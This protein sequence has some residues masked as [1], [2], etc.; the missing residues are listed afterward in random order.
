MGSSV[1]HRMLETK[2][3]GPRCRCPRSKV[4]TP[5]KTMLI[6]FPQRSSRHGGSDDL[7]WRRCRRVRTE[8]SHRWSARRCATVTNNHN[9]ALS[10]R[11]DRRHGVR[12]RL[13]GMPALWMVLA[14]AAQ[15]AS[16]E[17]ALLRQ[18]VG[19]GETELNDGSWPKAAGRRQLRSPTG[20]Q[21]NSG[22]GHFINGSHTG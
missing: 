17:V 13:V 10:Y 22:F 2:I 3:G 5:A 9:A 6:K 7:P 8:L 11:G 16:Q 1:V 20:G 4:A 12:G 15:E 18:L 19:N 14:S 21:I